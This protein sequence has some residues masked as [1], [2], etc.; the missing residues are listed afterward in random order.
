MRKLRTADIPAFCRC[1]KRLG[2]KE[3]VKNMAQQANNAKDVWSFGFDFIWEMFDVATEANGEAII[4]EFMAGPFEMTPE[5]VAELDL[6]VL[7]SNL[8]QMAEENN[9]LGFFK[10]AAASMK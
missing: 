6:D 7:I 5:Q 4:Y 8:Q 3:Q 10:S 2:L 1:V 9:L